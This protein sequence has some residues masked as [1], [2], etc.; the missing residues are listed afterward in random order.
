VNHR[1]NREVGWAK[2]GWHAQTKRY[3]IRS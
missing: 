1:K 3:R 2:T